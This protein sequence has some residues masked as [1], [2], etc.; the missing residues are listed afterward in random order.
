MIVDRGDDAD[1]TF[2]IER[3]GDDAAQPLFHPPAAPHRE[4][5]TVPGRGRRALRPAPLDPTLVRTAL[6]APGPGAIAPYAPRP[7]PEPPVPPAQLAPTASA[8]RVVDGSLPS[9]EGEARRLSL[10]AVEQWS[11][12]QSSRWSAWYCSRSCCSADG[13]GARVSLAGQPGGDDLLLGI[14]L[15]AIVVIS[16]PT[17][18]WWASRR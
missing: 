17:V 10:L 1:G 3:A 7:V 9:V 2:V 12:H 16:P 13:R 8:T 15:A 18:R 6:E 14:A 11:R 4:K 5:P